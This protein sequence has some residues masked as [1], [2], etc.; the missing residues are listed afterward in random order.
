MSA[1]L[2]KTNNNVAA[3]LSEVHGMS[4]SLASEADNCYGLTVEQRDIAIRIIIL[5]N[6]F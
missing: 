1:S 4:V 6:H 5:G 3:A 2:A